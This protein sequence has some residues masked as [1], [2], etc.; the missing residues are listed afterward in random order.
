MRGRPCTA[1]AAPNHTRSTVTLRRLRFDAA[2]TNAERRAGTSNHCY[3]KLSP[4]IS[5]RCGHSEATAVA[6][7]TACQKRPPVPRRAYRRAAAAAFGAAAPRVARAGEEPHGGRQG[8]RTRGRRCSFLSDG[9][10]PVGGRHQSPRRGGGAHRDR[11]C[12]IR[13]CRSNWLQRPMWMQMQCTIKS[14]C[15][16]CPTQTFTSSSP[17]TRC[18]KIASARE[19][20]LAQPA[21]GQQASSA[22][23]SSQ[24]VWFRPPSGPS[25]FSVFLRL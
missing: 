1:L 24:P 4:S 2:T 9:L 7:A 11:R 15:R 21:S 18:S 23:A 5:T 19:Q 25:S 14:R 16:P 12:W 10:R 3:P 8:E 13:P 6:R 22:A 17:R 20:T